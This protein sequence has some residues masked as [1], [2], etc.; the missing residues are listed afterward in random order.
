VH[1]MKRIGLLLAENGVS[2]IFLPRYSPDLSPIELAW[3]KIKSNLCS[4]AARTFD[5]LIAALAQAIDTV[6][7]HDALAWFGH[8][9][10]RIEGVCEAL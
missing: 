1:K 6:T 5:E 9:G 10:Y 2:V 8:C 4:A 3:S 7:Q